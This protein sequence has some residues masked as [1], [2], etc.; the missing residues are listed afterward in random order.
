MPNYALNAAFTNEEL[1]IFCA[2]GTNVVIAKPGPEG[3]PN[4]NWVVF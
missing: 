1:K 3:T 2:T 4:V